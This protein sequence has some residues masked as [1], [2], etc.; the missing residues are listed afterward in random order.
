MEIVSIKSKALKLLI[1][2]NDVRLLPAKHVQKTRDLID[3]LVGLETAE[4]FLRLPRGRP[5]RLKG[6]RANV[7]AISVY[8]NWRLTFEYVAKDNSIHI[9]DLEDYH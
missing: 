6:S 8:A 4:E 5:H 9:L 2:K 1:K 7:Y 3:I